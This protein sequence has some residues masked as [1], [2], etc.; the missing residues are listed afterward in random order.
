MSPNLFILLLSVLI[1]QASAVSIWPHPASIHVGNTARTLANPSDIKLTVQ[2][3][4][5]LPDDVVQAFHRT[6]DNIAK[7]SV[8]AEYF[9][10][11]SQ[12]GGKGDQLGEIVV[13]V[14]NKSRKHKR[15]IVPQYYHHEQRGHHPEHEH[16]QAR[17]SQVALH[18]GS[19]H[20]E[21]VKPE[22][23]GI[24]AEIQRPVT[25]LDESYSLSIQEQG[26]AVIT[27]SSSLGILRA[28]TTFEQLVF[29][30]SEG[31]YEIHDTPIKIE[32]SAAYPY[33]GLLIDTARNYYTVQS[34]KRQFDAMSL[35]KFNQ[36]HWHIVDSQSFPL[37]LDGELSVLSER[38]AYSPPEVYD[39][40]AIQEI[41]SYAGERG[42]NVNVEIDM[43]GHTLEGIFQYDKDLLECPDRHPW[44]IYGNEPPTGQLKIGSS[45]VDEYI[46]KLLTATLKLLPGPYFS[47]GNDEVNL[48]CYNV[49]KDDSK[50]KSTFD[51]QRLKP[52]VQK[53][54]DL[55]RSKDKKPMVWEEALI[56]FP[57]TG[58]TLS[59]GTIVQAW[60]TPDNVAKILS[61]SD[62]V[63]LL[64]SPTPYFYLDCG[65][66][67][68]LTN[69]TGQSYC[70]YVPF[71]KMYSFDPTNGT[72]TENVKRVVGGEACLWSEQSDSS[73]VDN[74]IWP[75][76]A[77]TSEIFWTGK[78]KEYNGRTSKLDLIEATKR[79]YVVRERLIK[80]GI[81]AT[82]VQPQW[83]IKHPD[84][85]ILDQV[86]DDQ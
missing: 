67:E 53:A 14:E 34:L 76:S 59:K 80:K 2:G 42:I 78:N 47:T 17:A 72:T 55:I 85:C 52:F 49:D 37:K 21:G 86:P 15:S 27:S 46:K 31:K 33:R 74:L 62:Q 13:R 18:D 60:T 40:K 26:P 69:T 9:S 44:Q 83:C 50:A 39:A 81:Q 77:A 79:L 30:S 4:K 12:E 63:L 32:D 58:K 45:K 48:K 43:P 84:S 71:G 24:A 29:S 56:D 20:T 66:G 6:M 51:S 28:L 38:G 19:Q 7:Y 16:L 23:K 61:S 10:S 11:R 65:R 73:T 82:P 5:R 68:W 36:F 75:R 57:E 8:D 1:A 35:L 41:V 70:D 22:L 25:E 64:H 3:N 54:H